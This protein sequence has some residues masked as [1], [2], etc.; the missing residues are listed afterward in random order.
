MQI[1]LQQALNAIMQRANNNCITQEQVQSLLASTNGVTFANVHQV[2]QVKTAAKHKHENIFKVTVASV[3][4]ANN[5]KQFTNVYENK[6]KRTAAAIESNDKQA[7]EQ[8][9]SASN[10][11]THTPCYSVVKHNT[12]DQYYLFAL[13][14]NSSSVYIHNGAIVDKQYVAQFLTPAAAK[15]LLNDSDTVTNKTHNIEHKAIVR[16]VALSSIVQLTANKETVIA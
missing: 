12:K 16:T 4:L 8:F 3:T 14:N 7:V 10:W 13:Y 2:T 6:V 11:F 15:Q 1:T 9:E 5:L